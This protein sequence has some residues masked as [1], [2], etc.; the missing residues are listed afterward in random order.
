VLHTCKLLGLADRHRVHTKELLELCSWWLWWS[1]QVARVT[2]KKHVQNVFWE[3]SWCKALM[4]K[5]ED[6]TKWVLGNPW[7]NQRILKSESWEIRLTVDR[8]G[9]GLGVMIGLHFAHRLCLCVLYDSQNKQHCLVGLK[10][11][12]QCFLWDRNWIL[13]SWLD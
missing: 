8:T 7:E 11:E 12:L 9:P 3:N 13:K 5:S 1:V 2:M 4:R 10:M 6:T